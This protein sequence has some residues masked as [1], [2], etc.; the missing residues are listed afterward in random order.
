MRAVLLW[1]VGVLMTLLAETWIVGAPSACLTIQR[2][3][4]RWRFAAR[5]LGCVVVGSVLA[6][7]VYGALHVVLPPLAAGLAFEVPLLVVLG[8]TLVF[9]AV[10]LVG[11]PL[12]GRDVAFAVPCRSLSG[13]SRRSPAS[14]PMPAARSARR[15]PPWRTPKAPLCSPTPTAGRACAYTG[16]QAS[17][18]RPRRRG[19]GA[20]QPCSSAR[21]S[22]QRR[23]QIDKTLI[24]A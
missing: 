3:G 24:F 10:E 15:W 7:A 2:A 18:R 20:V 9:I 14:S 21:R 12:R 5:G 17:Q 22:P 1:V 6:L 23:P 16:R 13:T 19:P 11:N 8:F 4:R